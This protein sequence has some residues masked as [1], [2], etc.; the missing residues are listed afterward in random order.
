MGGIG[1]GRY[2]EPG[3][4][5]LT[6]DRLSID[7][8]EWHRQGLLTPNQSFVWEWTLDGER[9]GSISVATHLDSV[10]LSYRHTQDDTENEHRVS[11]M[12][13]PHAL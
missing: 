10:I 11:V 6:T 2:S 5:E 12:L 3:A 8:L 7:V 4:K 13:D 1:S 9:L